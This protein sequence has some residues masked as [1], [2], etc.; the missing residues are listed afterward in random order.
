MLAKIFYKLTLAAAIS[1]ASL[2][3]N[4]EIF[5]YDYQANITGVSNSSAFAGATFGGLFSGT[6]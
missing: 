2:S 4:A 1:L 3:A 5:S 6:F